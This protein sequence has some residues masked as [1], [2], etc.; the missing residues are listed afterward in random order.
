MRLDSHKLRQN[1]RDRWRACC[2]GHGG[3]NPSALSIGVGDEGQ[4][5]LRCWQGC[6]VSQIV[7]AMGLELSDLFPPRLDHHRGALI[8]RRRLLPASQALELLGQEM[9]LAVVC[10]S[11]LAAGKP[12]DEPTRERL[13]HSAARVGML[14]E[15]VRS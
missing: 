13:L 4:V 10:A 2:P 3:S 11:D 6:E 9:T 1:G 8:A 15:E 5:L 7:A 14:L 12:L